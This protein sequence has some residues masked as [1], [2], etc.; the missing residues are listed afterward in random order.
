MEK[1]KLAMTG[2][3]HRGKHMFS[4][5]GTF[6]SVIPVA[7]CEKKPELLKAAKNDNPNI[8]AYENFDE[9]LEKEKPDMLLV[10]TPANRHAEFCIKGLKKNIHV[11][12]DIPCVDN[13]AEA[14]EFWRIEQASKAIFMTGANP[15][16]WAFTDTALD[17]KQKGLLGEPYYMEAEYIHDVRNLF[18]E[19]PWRKTY[20][21]IKYCTHSLGPLLKLI[22][23]DLEYV[24]CFDT[25]SHVT[26]EDGRH[27]AMVAIFKTKSNI[28]LRLLVSFINN[29]PGSFHSYKIYG[30]KGYFER[31]PSY[32]DFTETEKKQK[33]YFSST[34]LY[35]CK[36]LTEL[37]VALKR[38]EHIDNKNASGH[39]GADY[40]LLESFI[41]AIEKN[42]PSPIS[43]KEG[44][45]MTLPGIYA[46]ESAKNGG[47]LTK[48]KYPW[49]SA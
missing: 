46:A 40:A 30:T 19:T 43:L 12:S 21:G 48:I 23:E 47:K 44:L 25:G 26:K 16:M 14:D 20:E 36:N 15:N 33:T 6:Q 42:L 10:E 5:A 29:R 24:S 37:P 4:L 45:R 31:T 49:E 9:M 27:D 2:Y 8:S 38:P 28:V 13:A 1:I 22:K 7:V 39:G 34:E 11:M 41:K 17:L 32:P 3:G 35:G 18:E